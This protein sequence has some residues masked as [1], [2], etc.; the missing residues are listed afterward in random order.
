M[1]LKRTNDPF[2]EKYLYFNQQPETKVQKIVRSMCR[3]DKYHAAN[4]SQ[5]DAVMRNWLNQNPASR[6][7]ITC[8]LILQKYSLCRSTNVPRKIE[9]PIISYK[10]G[11]IQNSV[12]FDELA[13]DVNCQVCNYYAKKLLFSFMNLTV[14]KLNTD[15]FFRK[16]K[17]EMKSLSDYYV[18]CTMLHKRFQQPI[19]FL[20]NMDGSF[21]LLHLGTY[22]YVVFCNIIDIV[23]KKCM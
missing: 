10:N 20:Q 23:R 15:V 8:R 3:L 7:K 2:N 6:Y 17:H 1:Q 16:G 18:T 11:P 14:L 9:I 5:H 12:I 13:T 21:F 22:T 19:F 4:I